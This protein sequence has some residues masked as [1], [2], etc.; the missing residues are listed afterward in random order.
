AVGAALA[1]EAAGSLD[2][3]VVVEPLVGRALAVG[4]EG[5]RADARAARQPSFDD[6]RQV[7]AF[8][9]VGNLALV[10]AADRL[11]ARGRAQ[12]VGDPDAAAAP[13]EAQHQAGLG[14][15]AAI[16]RRADAE[17]PVV[18]VHARDLGVLVVDLGVPDERAVAE[19]PVGDDGRGLHAHHARKDTVGNRERPDGAAARRQLAALWRLF[20]ALWRLP[21]GAS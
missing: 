11:G 6:H 12:P 8:V 17:R 20:G 1:G 18:A 5:Q 10:E 21:G 2:D 15:R 4:G 14:G 9:P 16:A 19:D 3:L 13:V 7:D